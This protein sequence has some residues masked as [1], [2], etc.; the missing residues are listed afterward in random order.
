MDD[1]KLPS[2]ILVDVPVEV[3]RAEYRFIVQRLSGFVFHRIDE[4]G[5][6]WVKA[7]RKKSCEYLMQILSQSRTL[8]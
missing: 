3:S 6:Y 2:E 8:K 7:T 1:F 5:R 4:D